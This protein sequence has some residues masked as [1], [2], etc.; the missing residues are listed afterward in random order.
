MSTC[1]HLCF[2]RISS[3]F[4]LVLSAIC[5]LCGAQEIPS[6]EELMTLM[7]LGDQKFERFESRVS[8]TVQS[9][10]GNV[11]AENPCNTFTALN[12][13]KGLHS[14][15]ENLED[16]FFSSGPDGTVVFSDKDCQKVMYKFEST[17]CWGKKLQQP[18]VGSTWGFISTERS[19]M[20][21]VGFSP[22]EAMYGW[23]NMYR[24]WIMHKDTR[25]LL[26]E[27]G[28]FRLI[29][30]TM[31]LE[32]VISPRLGYVPIRSTRKKGDSTLMEWKCEDFREIEKDV[33]IPFSMTRT[34]ISDGE[35]D[36]TKVQTESFSYDKAME[37]SELTLEFPEGTTVKD[38]IAGLIYVLTQEGIEDATSSNEDLLTPLSDIVSVPSGPVREDQD[39]ALLPASTK[40]LR[41]TANDGLQLVEVDYKVLAARLITDYWA[42]LALS[43]A[44]FL[45]LVFFV[46]KHKKAHADR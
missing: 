46:I 28:N 22:V 37:D 38:D 43:A 20:A 6:V 7:D 10:K 21:D 16:H 2:C 27:E 25:V 32:F 24:D 11:T 39:L 45:C 26:D 30:E 5:A 12:R 29:N 34:I 42:I 8:A 14:Y 40:L 44:V 9:V 41:A 31:G 15:A 33:W 36:V 19:W 23:K 3:A 35:G 4:C 13:K 17:E 18:A 1:R